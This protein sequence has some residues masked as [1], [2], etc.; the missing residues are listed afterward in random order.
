VIAVTGSVGKTTTR[1]MI[2]AVLGYEAPGLASLHNFNNHVGLPL[3]LSRLAPEHEYAVVEL[4]ASAPG[5]I[6]RLAGLCRP[7]VAVITQ[8][9]DAHLCGFGSL[10]AIASS[11]TELL[12]ALP[13]SGLAVLNGDDPWL[14]RAGRSFG[15]RMVWFGRGVDCN[16]KATRV[17]WRGG[18]LRFEVQGQ[19]F[20][21]P[22]WGR[23]WLYSALAAVAVGQAVDRSLPQIAAALADFQPPAWRCEVSVVGGVRLINDAYN[24][25]PAAM[26]AALQLLYEMPGR[27]RR[28]FVCGDMKELGQAA[29][30]LHLELGRQAVC[31]GGVDRLIACGEFAS[32]VVRGARQAGMGASRARALK[33]P[34]DAVP[35]LARR[36]RPGDVVL[37]KGS[38]SMSMELLVAELR[39]ALGAS[40]AQ[41]A[42]P[43]AT[44][45]H[46]P[47]A[48]CVNDGPVVGVRV[49][50]NSTLPSLLGRSIKL[51]GNAVSG[52]TAPLSAS[53]RDF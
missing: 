34:Q 25:C 50:G 36:L 27:G 28:V 9:G 13:H 14:P 37:V 16:L 33:Q 47:S 15:G 41:A 23:H 46:E 30:E 39:R 10:Q 4:G 5:E 32:L 7:H 29:G 44:E 38:R 20:R 8:I 19:E 51:G 17:G 2:H 42:E 21:V 49:C 31:L 1:E 43:H 6:A 45:Q 26:T 35:Y 52:S 11:K 40:P 22:V 18:W 24:A 12:A 3:T 53:R 48:Q